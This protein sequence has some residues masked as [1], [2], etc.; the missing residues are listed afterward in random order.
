MYEELAGTISTAVGNLKHGGDS[1]TNGQQA[2]VKKRTKTNHKLTVKSSQLVRKTMNSSQDVD[3]KNKLWLVP[4][5]ELHDLN[6][7]NNTKLELIKTES[8]FDS[9][10]EAT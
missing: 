2:S 8:V 10:I 1:A 6:L 9:S 3:S 5:V 7:L 4:K